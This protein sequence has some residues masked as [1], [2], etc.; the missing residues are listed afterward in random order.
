MALLSYKQLM[1]RLWVSS[2][3]IGLTTACNSSSRA[4]RT[5][6]WLLWAAAAMCTFTH[7]HTP[8][9]IQFFFLT[10]KYKV[11]KSVSEWN[12]QSLFFS[13]DKR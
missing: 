1:Q 12:G 4:F 8:M 5:F 6:F 10:L 7:A 9:S 2:Q 13:K 11:E 3:Y